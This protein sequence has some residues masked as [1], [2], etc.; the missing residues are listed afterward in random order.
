M[1]RPPTR[2]SERKMNQIS[3]GR[4]GKMKGLSLRDA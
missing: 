1:I 4:E 2:R 3:G